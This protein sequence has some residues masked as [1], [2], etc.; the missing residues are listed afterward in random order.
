MPTSKKCWKCQLGQKVTSVSELKTLTAAFSEKTKSAG[1]VCSEYLRLFTARA[2]HSVLNKTLTRPKQRRDQAV[3]DAEE[4][5][6]SGGRGGGG[7]AVHDGLQIHE[8]DH[9]HPAP[10]AQQTRNLISA[11]ILPV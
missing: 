2:K 3:E 8:H 9:L 11:I 7:A 5:D 6:G 4:R 1:P 10:A